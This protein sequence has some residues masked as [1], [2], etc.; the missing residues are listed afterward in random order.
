[1]ALVKFDQSSK[2]LVTASHSTGTGPVLRSDKLEIT[3][4]SFKQ[5]NG[6]AMHQ[7]EAEQLMYVLEGRIRVQLGDSTYEVGVGEATFNPSNVPHSVH[8]LV[9]SVC[10]SVKNLAEPD[11]E[12]TGRLE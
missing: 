6:A 2:N 8:A 7:H 9:D 10:L 4:I 3:K 11:Y 5:G 12:A 1:M